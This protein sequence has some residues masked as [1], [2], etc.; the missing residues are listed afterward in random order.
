MTQNL[1]ELLKYEQTIAKATISIRQGISE[2]IEKIAGTNYVFM[3]DIKNIFQEEISLLSKP[4]VH[5]VNA[6]ER[7]WNRISGISGYSFGELERYALIHGTTDKTISFIIQLCDKYN[8]EKGES[9]II[10][11]LRNIASR[12]KK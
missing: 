11:E 5:S 1:G 2:I 8:K 6:L 10:T 12:Y 9:L 7:F 3:D 4:N